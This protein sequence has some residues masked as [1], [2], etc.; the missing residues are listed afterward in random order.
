MDIFYLL[1]GAAGVAQ[2]TCKFTKRLASPK[3]G[4]VE[5][6]WHEESSRHGVKEGKE[7][8]DYKT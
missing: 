8:Q 3:V 5:H 7:P 1:R 2:I 6:K 4:K